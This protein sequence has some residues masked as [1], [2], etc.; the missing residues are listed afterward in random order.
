MSHLRATASV[1]GGSRGN[2]GE[3]GCGFVLEMG[4]VVEEHFVY[5]GR[6]TNNV[7][8]YAGL[9][10]AMER[11]LELGVEEL[12]VKADSELLVKQLAGVYKVKAPHLQ[13]LWAQA[14]RH[15][16]RF[17][18]CRIRHV[19]RAH[20]AHADRLANRAMDTRSSTRPVPEGV[21]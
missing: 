14:K 6:T 16:A 4:E 10:G 12:V 20:N 3:A 5:L 18:V 17:K 2:P 21:R 1:D 15:S 9:L 7:A 11:A 19:M 13:P 8:E